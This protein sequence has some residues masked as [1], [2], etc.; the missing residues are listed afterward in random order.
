MTLKTIFRAILTL[1][2]GGLGPLPCR[3]RQERREIPHHRGNFLQWT[4]LLKIRP[5]PLPQEESILRSLE[6]ERTL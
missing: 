3:N 1:P 2:L 6:E 4:Q 5:Q